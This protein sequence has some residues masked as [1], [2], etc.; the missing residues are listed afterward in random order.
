MAE[1]EALDLKSPYAQRWSAV[2]EAARKSASCQQI[3]SLA[4][5]RF[6]DALRKV[7]KQFRIYGVTTSDF[8]SARDSPQRLREL[9]RRTKSHPYAEL[10]VSVLNSASSSTN[11]ECLSQ[12]G[13][14]ILDTV[15][16]QIG[17]RLVGTEHFPSFFESQIFFD[18]VGDGL[19]PDI[20]RIATNLAENPDWEPKRAPSKGISKEEPTAELLPI[21]LLGGQVR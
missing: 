15:F 6:Y 16:D 4:R 13:H 3:T 17:H 20:Q 7:T 2:R 21:S 5:Q 9:I 1:N 19:G 10:L 8:L 11:S 12:W 14:A 18:R